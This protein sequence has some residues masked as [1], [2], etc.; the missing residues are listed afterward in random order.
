MAS[1]QYN[2]S[3]LFT[4]LSV[5]PLIFT[6]LDKFDDLWMN[7]HVFLWVYLTNSGLA[8]D[9]RALGQLP[10]YITSTQLIQT[11]T[12]CTAYV[13]VSV[14]N[15]RKLCLLW[16]R[17]F[18]HTRFWSSPWQIALM[19]IRLSV[20]IRSNC[21]EFCTSQFSELVCTWC[22]KIVSFPASNCQGAEFNMS[23]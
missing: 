17:N 11:F 10:H 8:F 12:E 3:L 14:H 22:F 21:P 16:S 7:H 15:F 2:N 5:R 9:G 18:R 6:M 20:C 4:R 23:W 13:E 1:F 19:V